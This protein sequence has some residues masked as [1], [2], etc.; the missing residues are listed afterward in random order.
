MSSY[1]VAMWHPMTD[2]RKTVTVPAASRDGALN[3]AVSRN[4][5][6]RSLLA[7]RA[8]ALPGEQQRG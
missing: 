4:P 7:T 2:E 3:M 1:A 8:P 5:G 6:W